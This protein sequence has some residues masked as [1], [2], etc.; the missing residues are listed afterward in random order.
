MLIFY[1]IAGNLVPEA[2]NKLRSSNLLNIFKEGYKMNSFIERI[3]KLFLALLLL[4]FVYG[5]ESESA[6]EP[7]EPEVENRG[8]IF[9]TEQL[10]QYT[11]DNIKSL[12]SVLGVSVPFEPAYSVQ[13]I[14]IVYLTKDQHNHDAKA[15]GT[16][17]I[18]VDG[19][20]LPLFSIQH[21]TVTKR[22]NVTST[23]TLT[24]AEGMTGLLSSSL[25]YVTCIPDYI[26]FGESELM[27]P[28]IHA[29]SLS[30]CVIDFLR[31]A[32]K[33]CADKDITL[34]Q[35]VFLGG[36][37][38][39]GYV[40]LATQKEIELNYPNEFQLTA[41]APMAGPYDLVETTNSIF[42]MESYSRPSHIAFFLTAYNN[43]Y[44]WNRLDEIFNSPY[45]DMMPDLF[46]GTKSVLEINNQLPNNISDL[47]NQNFKDNYFSGNESSFNS[48][49]QENTLL[50]WTPAAP[51]R[52]YHGDSDDVVPYQNAL[53]AMENLKANGATNIELITITGGDHGSSGVPSVLGAI[54]WF[55]TIRGN[56]SLTKYKN[57]KILT[58]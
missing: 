54:E 46:D 30:I 19:S 27:H 20:G 33:Y 31:A 57:H 18:P 56:I 15:S 9:Y 8:D 16:I 36:Y 53:T 42:R 52:F 49:L 58:L 11:T 2:S 34:N 25:G 7:V 23:G 32:K 4:I 48:A 21:G 6:V 45:N 10:G 26:G 39:G 22:D 35:Q 50:N 55:N 1:T 29:K 47:I 51:I 40:T 14:K 44:G 17:M 3:V 24:S 43:I 28:Y 12:F 41:V 5:C 38:E 13:V 37:S